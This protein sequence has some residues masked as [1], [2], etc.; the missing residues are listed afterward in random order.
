MLLTVT[1][2]GEVEEDVQRAV[3]KGG[4][5][6]L[7]AD[8]RA[9]EREEGLAVLEPGD[10]LVRP[11]AGRAIDLDGVR[12]PVRVG[13]RRAAV[14]DGLV[15]R[16]AVRGAVR[17]RDAVDH[18]EDVDLAALRPGRAVAH[19]VAQHPERRPHALLVGLRGVAQPES[20]LHLHDLA[21]L[22]RVA[23]RRFDPARCPLA[24]R[25]AARHELDRAT[26]RYLQI[27]V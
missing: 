27:A 15:A 4:P 18:L 14:A 1:T 16:G 23:A 9:P 26:A 24:G 2:N 22:R 17:G 13:A 21:R 5:H 8:G 20:R 10:G 3:C 11:I 25:G 6:A 12:V 19:R 7:V